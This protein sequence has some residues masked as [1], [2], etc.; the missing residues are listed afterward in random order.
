MVLLLSFDCFSSELFNQDVIVLPTKNYVSLED[1]N[2]VSTI[3]YL[4]FDYFEYIK[5]NKEEMLFYDIIEKK[6][7]ISFP[8]YVESCVIENMQQCE[9]EYNIAISYNGVYGF[10][11]NSTHIKY[12]DFF[13]IT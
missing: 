13:L 10:S 4:S 5:G 6:S 8:Y 12:S 2:E 9:E 7:L 11:N 3:P 1:S